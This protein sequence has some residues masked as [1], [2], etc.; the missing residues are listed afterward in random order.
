VSIFRENLLLSKTTKGN[1]PFCILQFN[2]KRW[3]LPKAQC[4]SISPSTTSS[5]QNLGKRNSFAQEDDVPRKVAKLNNTGVRIL[6][7]NLPPNYEIIQKSGKGEE[8]LSTLIDDGNF[9][10][11]G[12]E[13][14]PVNAK[15]F[16]Q[17]KASLTVFLQ[18][19]M[20]RS[21]QKEIVLNETEKM[22]I[23]S[24][25]QNGEVQNV[26]FP[27]CS[28]KY[29][30]N[31]V[32]SEKLLVFET[33][34]ALEEIFTEFIAPVNTNFPVES[35]NT[36]VNEIFRSCANSNL[37]QH[38]LIPVQWLLCKVLAS[39]SDYKEEIII[40]N[41]TDS[42]TNLAISNLYRNLLGIIG[43]HYRW[44]TEST[45]DS[46]LFLEKLRLDE[47]EFERQELLQQ[48]LAQQI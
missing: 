9:Q 7:E 5:S 17:K 19:M 6:T 29:F 11:L 3:F 23:I 35:V 42:R 40:E 2:V 10:L 28:F 31:A 45:C 41:T 21:F 37:L 48:I 34:R 1:E 4:N 24:F 16:I 39:Y 43:Q 33:I 36:I 30:M 8:K 22:K 12:I 46:R 20:Y 44:G 47:W 13:N 26:Q 27:V 25:S 14:C 15:Y 38:E 18:K 32:L